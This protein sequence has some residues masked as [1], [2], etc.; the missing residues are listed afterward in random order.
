MNYPS[1]PELFIKNADTLLLRC[2]LFYQSKDDIQQFSG[3]R[4]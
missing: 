1:S 3:F 4:A 2:D